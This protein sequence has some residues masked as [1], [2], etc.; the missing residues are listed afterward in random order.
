MP[1]TRSRARK[2]EA[3]IDGKKKLCNIKRN[4]KDGSIS[5][6]GCVDKTPKKKKR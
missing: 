6:I 2:K 5:L 4:N 3:T 1:R